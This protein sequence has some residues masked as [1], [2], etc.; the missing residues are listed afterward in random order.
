MKEC[1][2][3]YLGGEIVTPDLCDYNSYKILGL[4]CPFCESP[5]FLR[6][7]T[8]YKQSDKEISRDACFAHFKADIEQ[9]ELC[10][11]RA[12]T[13]TGREEISAIKRKNQNQRLRLFFTSF[14]ELITIN[15][16]PSIKE[17]KRKWGKDNVD[18]FYSIAKRDLTKF[19]RM[20]A[21]QASSQSIK[22]ELEDFILHTNKIHQTRDPVILKE[23]NSLNMWEQVKILREVY[24]FLAKQCNQQIFAGLILNG[25]ALILGSYGED[26]TITAIQK[27]VGVRGVILGENDFPEYMEQINGFLMTLRWAKAIKKKLG[28]L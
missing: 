2:S 8:I 24:S 23:L 22:D 10:E 1:I 18:L 17:L 16:P 11:A 14:L 6:Q 12:L 27:A 21:I 5:V 20:C 4:K 7:G 28:N 13:K 25:F 19:K 26:V 3:I 9:G 15:N